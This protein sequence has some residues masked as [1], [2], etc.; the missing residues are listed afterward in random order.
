MNAYH[1]IFHDSHCLSKAQLLSYLKGTLDRDEIYTIETHLNSCDFCSEALDGLMQQPVQETEL[2]LKEIK[3]AF[4]EKVKTTTH[5]KVPLKVTKNSSRN[6]WMIAAS[7]IGLLGLATF[8]VYSYLHSTSDHLTMDN[9]DSKTTEGA[10]RPVPNQT[11]EITQIEVKPED[12]KETSKEVKSTE[13]LAAESNKVVT[14]KEE[15]PQE[16]DFKKTTEVISR[17]AS[18]EDDLK[19]KY[20]ETPVVNPVS[21]NA[22]EAV[23]EEVKMLKEDVS[24]NY[25]QYSVS[26]Q[27]TKAPAFISKK[28]KAGGMENRNYLNNSNI[29]SNQ[30]NNNYG[31]TNEQKS[32]Y[33]QIKTETEIKASTTDLVSK[34]KSLYNKGKYKKAIASF[35]EALPSATPLQRNEIY[36]FLTACYVESGEQAL[37]ESCVNMI[38][39]TD[40]YYSEAQKLLETVKTKK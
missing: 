23:T 16:K 38:S 1:D 10:Y 21:N 18:S 6:R 34:A 11:G 14:K 7:V 28:T 13:S 30:N 39:V 33:D 36:Y 9:K 26:K 35:K 8:S 20:A 37:A 31:N 27:E 25:K 22:P 5:P 24:S 19:E 3:T 4:Q 2:A 17:N 40:K 12:I 29:P 32:S 15:A